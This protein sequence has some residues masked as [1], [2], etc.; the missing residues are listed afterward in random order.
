MLRF[1]Y[2]V[3]IVGVKLFLG[4]KKDEPHHVTRRVECI[5]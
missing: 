5:A 2:T 3:G 1:Y 4:K